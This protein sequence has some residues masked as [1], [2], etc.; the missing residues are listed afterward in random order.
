MDAHFTPGPWRTK[1][2]GDGW[3]IVAAD[4]SEI[5]SAAWDYS[6]GDDGGVYGKSDANLIAAA[7]ELYAALSEILT[8]AIQVNASVYARSRAALAKA[9]GREPTTPVGQSK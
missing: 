1:R 5:V 6:G 9:E 7:P 8:T 3:N 4:G 2:H